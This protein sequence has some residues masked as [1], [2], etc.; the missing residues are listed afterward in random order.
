MN[1]HRPPCRVTRPLPFFPAAGPS[2]S[3]PRLA[4]NQRSASGAGTPLPCPPPGAPNTCC[5][6]P[7]FPVFPP[8]LQ[9][10]PTI[11][12]KANCFRPLRH[13]LPP[14]AGWAGCPS[15]AHP[16]PTALAGQRALPFFQFPQL[17]PPFQE[18]HGPCSLLYC[19]TPHLCPPTVSSLRVLL[20]STATCREIRARLP[21]ML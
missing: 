9:V 2:P 15:S 6:Q 14:P 21:F 13:G 8:I 5:F 11:P 7:I 16:A 18:G 12:V 4:P 10:V 17:D 19:H 20:V 3:F 1:E